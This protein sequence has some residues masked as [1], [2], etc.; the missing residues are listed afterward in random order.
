MMPKTP[1]ADRRQLAGK[2]R[3]LFADVYTGQ[4]K[5]RASAFIDDR[6]VNC[7]PQEAPSALSNSLERTRALLRRRVDSRSS[8]S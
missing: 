4:G 3:D 1:E 5:P 2:A 7:S 8:E 6:A